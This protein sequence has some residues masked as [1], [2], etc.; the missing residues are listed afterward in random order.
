[1]VYNENSVPPVDKCIYNCRKRDIVVF[2]QFNLYVLYYNK[3]FKFV[4]KVANLQRYKGRKLNKKFGV[5]NDL[6]INLQYFEKN[7]LHLKSYNSVL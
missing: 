6:L 5:K 4:N 3:K 2:Y 1:M 7:I